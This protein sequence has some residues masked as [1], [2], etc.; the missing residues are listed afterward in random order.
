MLPSHD[1][2]DGAGVETDICI[3]AGDVGF[4]PG[5]EAANE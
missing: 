3:G 1:G 4:G 5:P 2:I